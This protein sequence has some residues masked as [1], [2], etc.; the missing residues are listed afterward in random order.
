MPRYNSRRPRSRRHYDR[1]YDEDLEE[2]YDDLDEAALEFDDS[3]MGRCCALAEKICCLFVCAVAFAFVVALGAAAAWNFDALRDATAS[4]RAD[5]VDTLLALLMP[6][7]HAA[8][9]TPPPPVP[10]PPPPPLPPACIDLK[11][12]GWCAEKVSEGCKAD[13]ARQHC[14]QS[15]GLCSAAPTFGR[16]A[17]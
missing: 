10:P 16:W 11:G 1:A 7:T 6:E 8:A 13:Y 12:H 4:F 15:C 3:C 14:R 17:R 5:P 2:A 9:R